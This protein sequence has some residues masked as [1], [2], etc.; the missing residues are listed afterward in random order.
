[1]AT[2]FA[3]YTELEHTDSATYKLIVRLSNHPT[4]KIVGN[5]YDM[6]AGG[7]NVGNNPDFVTDAQ[8]RTLA[9]RSLSYE[10]LRE[11]PLAEIVKHFDYE[12]KTVRIEGVTYYVP[13]GSLHGRLQ[14]MLLC[15]YPD[16]SIGS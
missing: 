11:M 8:W 3:D 14:G 10:G 13:T 2:V 1:M 7:W 16:G 9:L 12:Q 15:V 5:A 4:Y 6:G